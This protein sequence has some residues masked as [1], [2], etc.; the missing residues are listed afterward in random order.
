M[1]M[2]PLQNDAQDNQIHFKKLKAMAERLQQSGEP[3]ELS[4]GTSHDFEIALKEGATWIRIGT[5]LFG[6]RQKVK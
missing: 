3:L 4:M 6:E 5:V 2:P 1:T